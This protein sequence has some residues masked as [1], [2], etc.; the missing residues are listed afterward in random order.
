[1]TV[2][3]VSA[4]Y[5]GFPSKAI[6]DWA[7][8]NDISGSRTGGN[9]PPNE[10]DWMPLSI[11]YL[12]LAM[13]FTLIVWLQYGTNGLKNLS[14]SPVFMALIGTIYL[15]DN[16]Y[17]NAQFTPF[18]IFV[19]TTAT[20]AENILKIM[21]YQTDMV[22]TNDPGIGPAPQLKVSNA[23]K[24]AKAYIAWPCSGVDSLIIY[25]ATSFLFI[26]NS[27]VTS[28]KKGIVYFT[29]GA[30]VTYLI[31]ILRIVTIFIIGMNYGDNSPQFNQFHSYYGA[32]YAIAWI[33]MYPLIIMEV[34][35]LWRY[36][37]KP[38]TAIRDFTQ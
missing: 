4:N 5:Y 12:V 15:I 35:A 13:L 31:N 38:K 11:E 36:I 22:F 33:V 20:L 26:K 10:C 18:Q 1:P 24:S 27:G 34:Q 14:I 30:V 32:L 8:Q 6:V 7:W 25:F 17:K 23:G 2:Y 9:R 21:G 16:F 3:I 19:P 37:S 29:I 28:W